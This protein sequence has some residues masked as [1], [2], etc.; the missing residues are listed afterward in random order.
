MNRLFNLPT[1]ILRLI[2]EYDST[3]KELLTNILKT[4]LNEKVFDNY[5]RKY[6]KTSD[7][8]YVMYCIKHTINSISKRPAIKFF[9]DEFDIVYIDDNKYGYFFKQNNQP[10]IK[11]YF[12]I[13]SENYNERDDLIFYKN[14][15]LLISSRDDEDETDNETDSDYEFDDFHQIYDPELYYA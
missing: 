12:Y 11:S 6:I 15:N 3:Y 13:L 4:E 2:Y 8:E 7:R 10:Y 1:D 5:Y 14:K 9:A